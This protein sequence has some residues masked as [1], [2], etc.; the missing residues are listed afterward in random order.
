MKLPSAGVE[1]YALEITT[2][3][4]VAG[5]EASFDDG[6]SWKPSTTVGTDGFY[7]WLVAGPRATA[8]SATVLPLG[9]TTPLVRATGSPEVILRS[10][11][12]IDVA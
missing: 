8:G 7:R 2:T 11:P 9:R 12:E 10:A 3:P 5:W 6:T 4:A 1:Y